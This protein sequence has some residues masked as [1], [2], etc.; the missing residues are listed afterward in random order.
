[1]RAPPPGGAVDYPNIYYSTY[2]V[3]YF[4]SHISC[5]VDPSAF[6]V[7]LDPRN[8]FASGIDH[9]KNCLQPRNLILKMW[10]NIFFHFFFKNINFLN[11]FFLRK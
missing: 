7:G 1:M 11:N 10:E 8:K 5:K 9:A 6:W 4:L 3:D 2:V